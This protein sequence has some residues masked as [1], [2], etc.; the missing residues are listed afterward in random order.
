[1]DNSSWR[2]QVEKCILPFS[3]VSFSLESYLNCDT[4]LHV[5]ACTRSMTVVFHCVWNASLV[6]HR[7]TAPGVSTSCYLVRCHAKTNARLQER[8]RIDGRTV[9]RASGLFTRLKCRFEPISLFHESTLCHAWLVHSNAL[10]RLLSFEEVRSWPCF[11]FSGGPIYLATAE[12]EECLHVLYEGLNIFSKLGT[13][14][15]HTGF[16][17]KCPQSPEQ[18]GAKSSGGGASV[19]DWHLWGTAVLRTTKGKALKRWPC[20]KCDCW[21][22]GDFCFICF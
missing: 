1:M 10:P 17:T 13:C 12:I 6:M 8:T 11:L 19:N 20:F 21:P 2:L 3:H 18:G 4:E 9:K 7:F 5:R 22:W 16:V 14:R 15:E